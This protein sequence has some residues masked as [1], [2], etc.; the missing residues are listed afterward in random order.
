MNDLEN[1]S[2]ELEGIAD[3][4][5]C[6]AASLSAKGGPPS[7]ESLER[8]LNSA[9]IHLSRLAVILDIVAEGQEG[10]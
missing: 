8:A 2:T 6:V 4:L 9:A 7:E 10:V 1:I 3:Q 5:V